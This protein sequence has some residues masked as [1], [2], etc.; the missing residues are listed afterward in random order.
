VSSPHPAAPGLF[1]ETVAALQQTGRA[2]VA[3]PDL[4]TVD[5]PSA[6]S[7]SVLVV[8]MPSFGC[9]V[10]YAVWP[11]AVEEEARPAVGELVL[12]ANTSL[13]TS[14]LEFDL[15]TGILS[16][17]ASVALGELAVPTGSPGDR[18]GGSALSGHA[19]A[20]LLTAALQE[21]EQV[22]AGHAD[23]VRASIGGR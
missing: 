8:V 15:G 3:H 23:A 19:F 12:R 22:R 7:D 5:V 17:R 10:F 16:A 6:D 21:V 18:D 4:E 2:I 11:E 1:S 20:G 9:V 13:Y 14:A